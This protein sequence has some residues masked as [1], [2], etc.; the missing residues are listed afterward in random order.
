M[1][2]FRLPPGQQ[3]AAIDKWPSVG[4]RLPANDGAPWT[5][6]LS[7]AVAHPRTFSLNELR[8]LPWREQT[9]DIHCVTR[10]TKFDMHFGGVLLADVLRLVQPASDARFVSF[11]ARSDRRH[12]TSLPLQDALSL[13]TLLAFEAHGQPLD[14]LHGGPVRTVVPRRY[15]YKSLKWLT[16]IELLAEDR[17]GHW[18]AQAGYHNTADPWLEQ[19]FIASSLDKRA[20]AALFNTR[21]IRGQEVLGLDASHR[22]LNG[23]Q[24]AGAILRNARFDQCQLQGANF[25]GANLALASLAGADLRGT[26]FRQAGLDGVDFT[27]ANLLHCDLRGAALTA[28][29]FCQCDETGKIVLA[30]LLDRTTQIDAAAVQELMPLQRDFVLAEIARP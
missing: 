15:F 27:G 16:G 10:W 29:T 2:D 24:A 5:V 7:G 21:D 3:L 13:E 14:V 4:E 28:A 12:S 23:L 25:D 8:E 17:L 30:A 18:E 6:T 1:H 11:V 26:S 20:A 9:T 22:D 19:R